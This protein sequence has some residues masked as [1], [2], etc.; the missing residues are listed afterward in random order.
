M[1]NLGTAFRNAAGALA[2]KP[3]TG[4]SS[5]FQNLVMKHTECLIKQ[6]TNSLRYLKVNIYSIINLHSNV[7][8]VITVTHISGSC[9][10]AACNRTGFS[11]SSFK[12]PGQQ[13]LSN[14]G[15]MENFCYYQDK[16]L[17]RTVINP[18]REWEDESR[19][20][21]RNSQIKGLWEQ[22]V[23]TAPWLAH[24]KT[25]TCGHIGHPD[26]ETKN[27]EDVPND[28]QR[29]DRMETQIADSS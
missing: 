18:A 8:E 4:R 26:Q 25:S 14:T 11:S 7:L 20:P 16:L 5:R 1:K 28:S 15:L 9:V 24:P 13:P 27:R 3:H 19:S 23:L 17:Q 21:R 2:K 22:N 12:K 29:W 10:P 6:H